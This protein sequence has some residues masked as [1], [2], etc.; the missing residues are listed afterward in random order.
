MF[1]NCGYECL[2]LQSL[3]LRQVFHWLMWFIAICICFTASCFTASWGGSPHSPQIEIHVKAVEDICSLTK[4]C[5]LG[6]LDT[7]LLPHPRSLDHMDLDVDAVEVPY[8]ANIYSTWLYMVHPFPVQLKIATL[9][10]CS[11]S[12]MGVNLVLDL[13]VQIVVYLSFSYYFGS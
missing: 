10:M 6:K 1:E 11:F 3:F 5:G 9:D 12:I 8:W 7:K 2:L 13:G 4:Y